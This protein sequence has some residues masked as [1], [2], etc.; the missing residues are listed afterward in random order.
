MTADMSPVPLVKGCTSHTQQRLS[1]QACS[2]NGQKQIY[3]RCNTMWAAL[4][5]ATMFSQ[6]LD[7]VHIINATYCVRIVSI[8][9]ERQELT[10]QLR[11]NHQ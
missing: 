8:K 5:R 1:V 4:T 3:H 11:L 10:D 9:N 6:K 7:C 2:P